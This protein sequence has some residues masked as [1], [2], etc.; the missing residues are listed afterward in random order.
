ME[1]ISSEK[2]GNIS[3]QVAKYQVLMLSF[4]FISKIIIAYQQSD[5]VRLGRKPGRAPPVAEAAVPT[6]DRACQRRRPS[7]SMVH[8]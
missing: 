5:H 1:S 6:G 8:N 3:E 2:Q 4:C 7:W